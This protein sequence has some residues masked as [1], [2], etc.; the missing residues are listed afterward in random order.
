MDYIGDRR[1]ADAVGKCMPGMGV[2]EMGD[3]PLPWMARRGFWRGP[4]ARPFTGL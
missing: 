1:L 4:R 3:F 2:S